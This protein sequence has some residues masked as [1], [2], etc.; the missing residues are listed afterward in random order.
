MKNPNINK[1][2]L[3]RID[4]VQ[5][6]ND[7]STSNIKLKETTNLKRNIFNINN[8]EGNFIYIYLLRY[9]PENEIFQDFSIYGN[10]NRI[11]KD[12][13]EKCFK[14]FYDNKNSII[15]AV[16][17]CEN[18]LRNSNQKKYKVEE[19]KENQKNNLD[20]K[21][22]IYSKDRNE[23]NLNNEFGRIGFNSKNNFGGNIGIAYS[24]KFIFLIL[25]YLN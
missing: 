21:I 4:E 5:S 15:N 11:Y 6:Q 16:K 14:I 3:D 13:N 9:V 23:Q 1:Q 8:T 2:P 7:N 22:L 17:D 18:T 10:I 24:G 12:E 25:F 20:F 19:G